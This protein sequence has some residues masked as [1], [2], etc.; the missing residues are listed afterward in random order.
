MILFLDFEKAFDSLEWDYLLKVLNIM[1]FGPS[2]L[3]W[4]RTFYSN[5]SSCVINNG[6]SSEFFSL[7]RGV[8]QGCPLSGLLFVLA[9]EP[10][11]HQIRT[12]NSIKGLENG[13]KITKLSLY[14]DDTTAFVRDD[15][16]AASLFT[17]LDQFSTF[18]GL[19]INKSKIEGLWLGRWK[20]RLGKDEPFGISW[21]KNYVT[22]LGIAFPY[23]T[24]AGIKLNFDE[25]LAK[26]KKV[27]NI[28]RMRH[29][30]ILGR[31]AIVKNLAISKL[32]FSSSVLNTPADFV[33]EVNSNIFSFVWN[34]KP[35][36]I[37]R[38]TLIGPACKGGLNMVNFVDVVKSLKIT[39]VKRYCESTGSHWCARLDSLLV[40]VGGAF[41]FQCNYD[42]KMLNLK[43]LPSFYKNIL[44]TWQELNRK[45][46]LNVNEFK[47]EIIWNNRF[48]KTNGKTMY[49]KAWVN[50]GV[51]KISDLLDNHDQFLSFEN[52]KRKFNVRCTFL[53]YGGVIAAIPKAWRNEIT[54]NI[55]RD[56]SE[57]SNA[58]TNNHDTVTAK[59]A[60]LM[61]AEKSFSPPTV[62]ITLSNLVTNV[63]DVYEL[64][65]RVTIESKMRSFQYKLIHNIIRTNLS[66]HRM[67]IKESPFCDHCNGQNETLLHRFCECPKAKSFWEDVIKWWNI[68]RS[69]NL[70]PNS[71]EILYGYKPENTKFH[72]FNY[73]LLIAKYH[74]Y[75]ARNQSETP[76]M[77]VFLALL[78]S[79]IKCERQI[80][81][82]N[83]NNKKYE[84][85][86]TTLCI[87]N[88]L[89]FTP[90]SE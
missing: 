31:I 1:N 66:L 20:N 51:L 60:R 16:S 18:S 34:F 19:K 43:N 47:Q 83:S 40:K 9:V 69:D 6:H 87:S 74:L 22:A 11:A 70:K 90:L 72:A 52:F 14:A 39:W 23:S 79:K 41:L 4:I 81:I 84:A 82:K 42:L 25:K 8:R 37:K 29:L 61:L 56:V 80:A 5:I 67:K 54:S 36:K 12:T 45:K 7:Q 68:R 57:P 2:F 48:I 78:E 21:P 89:A 10:L 64:P 26:L 44:E 75:L 53:D 50:K 63:K 88:T 3:N 73:Y 71:C 15:S 62:E 65:F 86:W 13:N 38:K 35:D 24:N 76:S 17:L 30:T 85:K 33:K 77:K 46:P 28:W 32:V 55:A 58:D 49:N 27:L 59:Q